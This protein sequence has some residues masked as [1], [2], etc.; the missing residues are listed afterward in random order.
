MTDSRLTA[1]N[2]LRVVTVTW[3]AKNPGDS[4]MKMIKEMDDAELLD[5]YRQLGK[6]DWED[7]ADEY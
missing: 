1:A 2:Q 4:G 6:D 7:V 5:F 3:P